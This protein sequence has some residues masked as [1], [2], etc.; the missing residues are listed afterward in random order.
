MSK[1][2]FLKVV[3]MG[4]V[5]EKSDFRLKFSRGRGFRE[6][7]LM[8]IG[9]DFVSV[10]DNIDNTKVTWQIW[11]LAG[12]DTFKNV[13]SRFFRGSMCALALFDINQRQSFINITRWIEEL[14]R[15]SGRGV[16]PV[17]LVG[18]GAERRD[19]NSVSIEDA[20]TY[21]SRLNEKLTEKFGFV[22]K[23][24]DS[25]VNTGLNIDEP[26]EDLGRQVI[27]GLEAGT[28]KLGG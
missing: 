20:E 10:E 9:A 7:H 23:Y 27:T 18:L 2:Y 3:L 11:D 28:I 6:E 26:F 21:A 22:V 19:E 12:Q 17:N 24:F 13:R 14:W 1:P 25:S 8:T 4:S 5:S 15:N 16:V